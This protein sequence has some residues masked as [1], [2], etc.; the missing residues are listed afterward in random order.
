MCRQVQWGV[1]GASCAV[2]ELRLALAP[3]QSM[4]SK[5]KESVQHVNLQ[6]FINYHK[7][8]GGGCCGLGGRGL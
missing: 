5:A 2:E 8:R 6:D 4:T 1:C 7:V 3:P